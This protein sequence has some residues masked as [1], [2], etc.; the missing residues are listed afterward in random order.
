MPDSTPPPNPPAAAGRRERRRRQKRAREELLH[1]ALALAAERPFRE[2]TVEQIAAGAGISRSAFYL[3]FGDK[4]ELVCAALD[5]VAGELDG[6]GSEWWRGE[7]PPAELV[8]DAVARLVSVYADNAELLRLVTEVAAYDDEVRARWLGLVEDAIEAAA[9]HVRGEQRAGLIPRTVQARPT[10]E[11]LVWMAERCCHVY[12]GGGDRGPAELVDALAPIWTAALYPG[13][14]PAE[15]LRPDPDE[16]GG[17]W[18]GPEPSWPA[19]EHPDR[20][21]AGGAE[22]SD[23]AA[24][25]DAA[26]GTG[27]GS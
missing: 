21:R 2:V 4:Q 13:V 26:G 17:P 10:C 6:L 14:V 23:D 16:G 1:A 7:G 20:Q 11:G 12:V 22:P 25:D 19:W 3:H 27:A 24:E 5:D 9:A 8:R 15:Q 18:G